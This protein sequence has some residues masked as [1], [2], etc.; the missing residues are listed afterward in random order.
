MER[1]L[2]YNDSNQNKERAACGPFY[3]LDMKPDR[4]NVDLNQS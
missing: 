3:V 4:L 2:E 1:W